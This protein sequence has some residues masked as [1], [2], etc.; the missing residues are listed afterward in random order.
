MQSQAFLPRKSEMHGYQRAPK[1]EV[2]TVNHRV[3]LLLDEGKDGKIDTYFFMDRI[4]AARFAAKSML[5]PDVGQVIWKR[6]V[7]AV[8]REKVTVEAAKPCRHCGDAGCEYCDT[9]HQADMRALQ[10]E[11]LAADCGDDP[12]CF[13]AN[14]GR[15]EE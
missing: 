8:T 1:P 11:Q 6:G 2:I 5:R 14:G 15:E 10:C 4:A 3:Q 7:Y 13:P 9:A 12:D